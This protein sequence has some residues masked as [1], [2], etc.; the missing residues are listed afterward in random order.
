MLQ[1]RKTDNNC[2]GF[3]QARKLLQQSDISENFT[4]QNLL[5]YRKLLPPEKF[6]NVLAFYKESKRKLLSLLSAD[7]FIKNK[8]YI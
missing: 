1:N 7:S 2:I 4:F 8:L 3:F 6:G 5:K